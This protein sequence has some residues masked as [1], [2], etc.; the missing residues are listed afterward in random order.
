[1]SIEKQL[2]AEW[3]DRL[4]EYLDGSLDRE[5]HDAV[6]AHLAECGACRRVLEELRDVVARASSLG[7]IAPPRDLWEGIA[8]T[9]Q[10]PAQRR[11]DDTKVIAFPAGQPTARTARPRLSFSV[12]QLVAASVALVAL[13][14]MATWAGLGSGP[15]AEPIETSA[16]PLS[17]VS[18]PADVPP[19][20]ATELLE[21]QRVLD[22]AWERLDPNTVRVLERNLGVIEQAIDDSMR[23]LEQDP[24][25][26]FLSEHLERV[27]ER[28]LTYLRDAA[29]MV[30]W[31]G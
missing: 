22:G 11:V 15:T 28:K 8:G 24:G 14:S 19:E 18:T 1:M 4:S 27:Y 12:P 21:L 29:Q 30:E 10:A 23:A 31:T 13:S 25:N 9:I 26:D 20:L 6:E 2:H 3:V 7:D 17:F 5:G 16:S